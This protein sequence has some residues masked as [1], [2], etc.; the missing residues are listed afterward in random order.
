MIRR[1]FLPFAL[2][3][4]VAAA[5][6]ALAQ[7]PGAQPPQPQA[8]PMAPVRWQAVMVSGDASLP[9]WDNAV[10][11]FMAG[12][13]SAQALA[14]APVRLSSAGGKGQGG[15]PMATAE[16]ILGAVA[17]MR[18][19]AGEGC[20][21][22]A[23]SHGIPRAGLSLTASPQQPLTPQALD[24]AI[25]RGGCAQAPTL[26]VI[27]GC[28]S[29]DFARVLARPNRAVLTAARADRPSFGCGAGYRFTVFDECLLDT[30]EQRPALWTQ[31]VTATRACVTRREQEMN[32]NPSEP[33][34]SVGAQVAG[35]RSPLSR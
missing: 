21:I 29:G 5:A 23:T 16:A 11:R 10:Q 4:L 30:L 12:L 18:P 19:A 17:A 14:G 20:L 35:L 15:L 8:A 24:A 3:A 1:A 9:V 26:V 34:A 28:Y 13:Q 27:S 6:P 2:F 7:K 22:F 25:S 33:Q 31:A 32:A